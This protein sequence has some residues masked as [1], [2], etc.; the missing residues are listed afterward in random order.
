MGENMEFDI[1]NIVAGT[2]A[3]NAR[4]P[5]CI[6]G[7]TPRCNVDSKEPKVNWRNFRKA[8]ILALR[9]KVHSVMITGKGEPTLYPDQITSYMNH[10][11][12]FNFPIIELQTNGILF[13]KNFSSYKKYLK[14]WYNKGLDIILISIVHY[15]KKKNQ[16]LIGYGVNLHRLIK[17]LHKI[18]FSVRLNCL[19]IKN[20][21]DTIDEV[22]K[23]VEFSKKENVEQLTFRNLEIPQSPRN[24]S[25]SEWVM[26]NRLSDKDVGKIENFFKRNA[27]ELFKFSFGAT[28]YDFKGQNVCLSNCLVSRS[29]KRLRQLIFFPDGHIRYNWQYEG[30]ILL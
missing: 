13:D 3:C 20:Y 1:F 16:S 28:V 8:C 24:K 23:L 21:I 11:K 15:D 17:N 6:S 2:L 5:F 27:R 10:L 30:A 4:C 18:G 25:I 19:F 22:L 7:M 26:K 12:N 29:E 9:S 14:E